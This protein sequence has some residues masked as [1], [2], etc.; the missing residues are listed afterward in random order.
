MNSKDKEK[1]QLY[2]VVILAIVVFAVSI[3]AFL[4]GMVLEKTQAKAP[5][6]EGTAQS[7]E[8]ENTQNGKKEKKKVTA[9]DIA[10]T[11]LS[12]ISFDSQLERMDPAIA[13]TMIAVTSEETKISLYTGEGTSSDELLILEAVDADAAEA[14][15]GN[16]Q[17]HLGEMQTS[18]EDYLPKEAKK[19][20][21]AVILQVGNYVIACVTSDT[22]NAREAIN[23]IQIEK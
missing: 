13:Q 7:E 12:K 5:G 23:R 21:D 4:Q 3:W 2:S 19:I 10:E 11:L 6:T 16:V 18:F 14:E 15:L 20:D 1:K 8:N 17:K 9:Q 22:E